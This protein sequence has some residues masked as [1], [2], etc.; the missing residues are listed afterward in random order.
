MV[1]FTLKRDWN[2]KNLE[3]DDAIKKV[4]RLIYGSY[5]NKEA[6]D[7]IISS[8]SKENDDKVKGLISD[9]SQYT[10][11]N[12]SM[13]NERVKDSEYQIKIHKATLN[14]YEADI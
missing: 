12:F 13:I 9:I 8:G 2:T 3:T 10:K 14:E 1:N 6:M 4:E 7:D 5:Y 11:H